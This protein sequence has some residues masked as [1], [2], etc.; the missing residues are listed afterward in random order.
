MKTILKIDNT[1]VENIQYT[2]TESEL[3]I[4]GDR[5]NPER[6]KTM[7]AINAKQ[8]KEPSGIEFD[9][10]KSVYDTKVI[11]LPEDF[12]FIG[13]TIT[14]TDKLDYAG[15]LNYRVD[16]NHLQKRFNLTTD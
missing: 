3:L 5:T 13:F 11:G 2:P 12:E 6:Q 4:I 14:I 9:I 10:A 1:W 15:I 8:T 16:G 7:N